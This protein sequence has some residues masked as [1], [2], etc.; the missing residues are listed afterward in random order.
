MIISGKLA[1]EKRWQ[2][3]YRQQSFFRNATNGSKNSFHALR[4]VKIVTAA[5]AGKLKG[6]TILQ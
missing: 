1:K 2:L 3:G 4:N 5:S 6:S